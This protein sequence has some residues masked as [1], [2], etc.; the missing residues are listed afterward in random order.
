[1]RL[2]GAPA[3]DHDTA[4]DDP[5]SETFAPL[6]GVS[7]WSV[8]RG[9]GSMLSFQFGEPRLVIREP[10]VSRSSSAKI[11]V[12]AAR[13]LV[14]PVGEWGLLVFCCRW[15]A[16]AS[17]A[18]LADDDAAHDRIEEAARMLDGQ[19]LTRFELDAARRGASFGFDLGTVLETW[20]YKDDDGEQWSLYRAD[21]RVL[22]YR[23]DGAISLDPGD[24]HPD[25]MVWRPAERNVQLL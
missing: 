1:M 21:G 4:M 24:T 16:S 23:A 15:R 20:P 11:R 8:E 13:R 17:G 22:T 7:C 6:I 19:R 3:C 14:K 25:R 9:Q 2:R 18:T 10:Y 5:F 12:S